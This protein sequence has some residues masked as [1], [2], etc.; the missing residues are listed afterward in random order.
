MTLEIQNANNVMRV[1][2]SSVAPLWLISTL[3]Y[4]W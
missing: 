1:S 3:P 2:T 4:T